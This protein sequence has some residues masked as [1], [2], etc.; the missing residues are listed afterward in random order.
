MLNGPLVIRPFDTHDS[1]TALTELLHRAYAALGQ[2]GLN[3]TAVDQS[4]EVTQKRIARGVCFLAF[5]EAQLVGT[6]TVQQGYAKHP[7]E[8][9]TTPDIGIINQLAVEPEQ[10][11]QG[12]GR[13]LLYHAEQW[14][15]EQGCRY[16]GLDTAEPARHLLKRYTDQGYQPIGF[17]QWQG[18][19]YRSVVLRKVM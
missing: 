11:G 8:F 10:Q 16:M 18:K 12:V 3:Y 7:C 14:A 6:V 5:L 2:L 9:Y 1:L 17:T 15:I 4:V 13:A 19:T